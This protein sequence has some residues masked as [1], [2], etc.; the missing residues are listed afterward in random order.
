MMNWIK[1]SFI[2]IIIINMTIFIVTLLLLS[3]LMSTVIQVKIQTL[4]ED[5][6]FNNILVNV[7]SIPEKIA[8]S[9]AQAIAR[10][11]QQIN[12]DTVER[13]KALGP[14]V[15]DETWPADSFRD[16]VPDRRA[17]GGLDKEGSLFLF[18]SEEDDAIILYEG[19]HGTD[20]TFQAVHGLRIK[21]A[22]AHQALAELD[23]FRTAR[24]SK[25]D[26]QRAK[27]AD[28][29]LALGKVRAMVDHDIDDVNVARQNLRSVKQ[30]WIV[31]AIGAMS[32][33]LIGGVAAMAALLRRQSRIVS[34]LRTVMMELAAVGDDRPAELD[35]ISVPGQGRPDEIGDMSR[36]VLVFQQKAI[37]TV[38]LRA[39][40]RALQER[41]EQVQK[42]AM[43]ALADEFESQIG[44]IIGSVSQA[45]VQMKS[46]ATQLSHNA[47]QTSSDLSLISV[48]AAEASTNVTTVASATDQLTT[49]SQDI[50]ER[51]ERSLGVANRADEVAGNTTDLILALADNVAGIGL[52]VD[53]IKD[54]ASQTNLLALNAT[55]EAARAGDAG[56]GFSVVA[57]EVK[58]LASQTHKATEEIAKRIGAVQVGTKDAVSA[59]RVI[60]EVISEV[61]NISLQ[62]S[63]SLQQ[64]SA[65]TGEIGRNID[66]AATGTADVSRGLGSVEKNSRDSLESSVLIRDAADDLAQ[67]TGRLNSAVASFLTIV[68]S[69][70]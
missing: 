5:L 30:R 22:K 27:F 51:M 43:Q 64:Q 40:Q 26:D 3:F 9:E 18:A 50:A 38:K 62:V 32:L 39:N 67:Q 4:Y 59:V 63:E 45:S 35:A 23:G 19:V 1:S 46:S 58:H 68:R 34:R 65:A 28:L 49:S 14:V 25:L 7:Q 13:A 36:A 55:I 69:S 10:G 12:R 53:L 42:T 47:K 60:A 29:S 17:R 66:Q 8:S 61:K 20:G 56:K 33:L 52:I 44:N 31:I 6:I 54:I 15:G 57:G 41:M 70:D 24:S 11:E 37:S 48:A 2:N 21:I 16:H